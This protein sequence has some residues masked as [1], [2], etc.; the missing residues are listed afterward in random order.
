MPRAAS[1]TLDLTSCDREPIHI[2]GHTQPHGI[3]LGC[4]PR[5]D[6]LH[7]L[8]L[9]GPTS[10]LLGC[11]QEAL[12]ADGGMPLSSLFPREIWASIQDAVQTIPHETGEEAA[13]PHLSFTLPGQGAGAPRAFDCILHTSGGL[14]LL[15]LEPSQPESL[16]ASLLQADV[17]R[18][19]DSLRSAPDVAT[20]QQRLAQVVKGLTGFDRV[21]VY[22]FDDDWHGEVVAEEKEARLQPF[23]GLHYPASDI[24]R[25]ARALYTSN[26]IRLI[27]DVAAA[28]APLVPTSNP[29]TGAPLDLSHSVLRSVS[30]IHIEYLKNMGVTASMSISLVVQGR[31]WGL[32]ACHNESGPNFVPYGTRQACVLLGG[33]GALALSDLH[34]KA[35]REHREAADV[36]LNVLEKRLRA[37]QDIAGPLFDS[38]TAAVDGEPGTPAASAAAPTPEP[39]L[40]LLD[41]QGVALV[42]PDGVRAY[43]STPPEKALRALARWLWKQG[44]ETYST[45]QL[46]TDYPGA[47]EW[48]DTGAGCIWISFSNT[49]P[50]GLLWFRPEVIQTV[51]WAGDP[52]KSV[53]AAPGKHVSGLSPRTSF[54][55]WKQV[56]QGTALPWHPGAMEAAMRLRVLVQQMELSRAETTLAAYR[57]EIEASNAEMARFTY[58]V[59]HDLRSPLITIMGFLGLLEEDAKAG[60][61]DQFDHYIGRI[62]AAATKMQQLLDELLRLSRVG[63]LDTP[64]ER[65]DMDALL[66]EVLEVVEGRLQQHDIQVQVAPLPPAWGVPLRIHEVLQNLLDNAAKALAETTPPREIR[67]HAREGGESPVYC[68]QDNGIGI[69]P[70]FQDKIF[71]LFE[72]LNPKTDGSGMGLALVKRI[73]EVH[74]GDIWVESEGVGHGTTFCFTLPAPTSQ[75]PS[76]TNGQA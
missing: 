39:L 69:D 55:A 7:I 6:E 44:L 56:V 66:Q 52:S 45:R 33:L 16:C 37:G 15:E 49:M 3:L 8:L 64:H 51:E 75:S 57:K 61:L 34:H 35:L 68:V 24:P 19:T 53:H 41:A 17:Q 22:R 10:E 2:L 47:A 11:S 46:V 67:I 58:A 48:V 54:A 28:P 71:Q 38:P 5:E 1:G 26:P 42:T 12:L 40:A 43:G 27:A 73:M 50:M 20:L 59:S 9:A 65:I 14:V 29:L 76:S 25:Q 60:T 4:Q 31:L 36:H 74:G 32:I 18:A 63:R 62:G 30:P 21:M 70:R 13:P 72:K 23:M